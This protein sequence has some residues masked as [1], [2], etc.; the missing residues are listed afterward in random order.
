MCQLLGVEAFRG[1][2]LHLEPGSGVRAAPLAVNS[3]V[4]IGMPQVL[5]LHFLESFGLEQVNIDKKCP[6]TGFRE[7]A[8]TDC[9]E[10]R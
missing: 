7:L 8:L 2:E 6:F 5:E 3:L 1:M 9:G 10:W 4:L